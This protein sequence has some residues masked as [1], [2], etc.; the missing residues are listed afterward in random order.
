MG[1]S[2]VQSWVCGLSM[3]QQTVLLTSLRGA[4]T[5]SKYHV[6]KYLLRWVRRCVLISAFDNAIIADPYDK[7]GGNFTGPIPADTELGTLFK[8][9]LKSVDEVPHHFHLHLIH[10]AEI[11][12]YKHPDA[13]I[14]KGWHDFYLNAVKDMHMYPESEA[15]LDYRL[16]DDQEQWQESGGEALDLGRSA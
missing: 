2:V 12:G 13:V 10:T 4:D 3:M 16:G 5:V 1:K 11:L 15:Q 8:Q 6:S 9:Y 14:R 7:R